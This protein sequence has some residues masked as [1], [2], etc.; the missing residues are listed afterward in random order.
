M[1]RIKTRVSAFA[2]FLNIV[3][4]VLAEAIRHEKEIKGI[5]IEKEKIILSLL[6]D[7]MISYVENMENSVKNLL[8]LIN[9]F[10]RVSKY[11]VAGH[12]STPP[13]QLYYFLFSYWGMVGL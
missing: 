4:E 2:T 3:L 13:N 6:V 1:I 10:I 9:E 12:K 8:E 5:Q 11:H 7:D